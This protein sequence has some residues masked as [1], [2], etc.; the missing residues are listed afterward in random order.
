M[1][2]ESIADKL[3]FSEKIEP[4]VYESATIYFSDIVGFTEISSKSTPIQVCKRKGKHEIDKTKF[5]PS[6]L[7][8][9]PI[10]FWHR[11]LLC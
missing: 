5:T 10:F 11:L 9:N 4:E 6:T 7:T 1:L 8:L 2:P 3:L